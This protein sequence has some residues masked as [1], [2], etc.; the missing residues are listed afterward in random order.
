VSDAGVAS[1]AGGG[2]ASAA[3]GDAAAPHDASADGSASQATIAAYRRQ[4]ATF[5][6]GLQQLEAGKSKDHVRIA[7]LGDSHAAA[8]F[9]TGGLRK[10]LQA[11][12]GNGGPG[13]VH[14]GY[15]DYRHDGVHVDVNGRWRQRPKPPTSTLP[16][17]DGN[18]G[19][20]G[21]LTAGYADQPRAALKL[22]DKSL[23]N[24]TIRWE[25]CYKLNNPQDAFGVR[26]GKKKSRAIKARGKLGLLRHLKLKGRGLQRLNVLPAG[27]KPEFCGVIIEPLPSEGAGVV[28]DTL[29]ING[30]RYGT[31][32]AWSA[33]H[34]GAELRRRKPALVVLE[35][36]GNEAGDLKPRPLVYKR[37]LLRLIDRIRRVK[38]D[39][40]CLVIGLSDR[41]DRSQ[42]VEPIRDAQREAAAEADCAFWD[43]YEKMGGKGSMRQ[44]R[45]DKRAYEDEIHFNLRGYYQL[46]KMLLTDLL[47]AYSPGT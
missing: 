21:I 44:W 17:G 2:A 13:F 22:V 40:S 29:G 1:S 24:R 20:G 6:R 47:A 5:Y 46:S 30:A 15:R 43:T 28:L 38:S 32:L 45:A 18:F 33:P 26:L 31:A 35:Y 9:W 12:F 19:L 23:R 39:V 3:A 16:Y 37:Q 14:L 4:L 11:R 27:G 34:W 25:L 10:A 36:G 42:W 41:T 8:D 7:W